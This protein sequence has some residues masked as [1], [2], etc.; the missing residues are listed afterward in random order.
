M[1]YAMRPASRRRAIA[2][3]VWNQH[4]ASIPIHLS[5]PAEQGFGSFSCNARA[6]E[7]HMRIYIA[8]IAEREA[9][10][11]RISLRWGGDP[12]IEAPITH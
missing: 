10:G 1:I 12:S 7:C 11:S 3:S 9:T 8:R 4:T 6:Q 2:S 5:Q